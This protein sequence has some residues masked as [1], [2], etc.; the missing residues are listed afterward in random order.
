MRIATFEY[1]ADQ[2]VTV[3]VAARYSEQDG[4]YCAWGVGDETDEENDLDGEELEGRA[5]S[6]AKAW[7][8]R[9]AIGSESPIDWH[10]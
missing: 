4:N 10:C 1:D 6:A 3:Y 8:K 9:N 7:V 2:V 5:I